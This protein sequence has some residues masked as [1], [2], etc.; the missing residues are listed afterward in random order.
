M[1][2]LFLDTHT[3]GKIRL[4]VLGARIHIRNVWGRGHRILPMI[5]KMCARQKGGFDGIC[6]VEGPGAFSSIRIGVLLAN[7]LATLWR[8][9]LV[10]ISSQEAEDL[11]HVVT[12]LASAQGLRFAY[13][14]PIYDAEPNITLPVPP[15]SP[16]PCL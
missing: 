6:V 10:A 9:P 15:L 12:R 1:P 8:K 14:A 16:S 7:V 3:R 2:W 4:G 5:E 13:V 11:R